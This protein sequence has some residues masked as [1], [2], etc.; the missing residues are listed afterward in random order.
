MTIYQDGVEQEQIVL[1]TLETRDQMHQMMK[2]KGFVLKQE[3]QQE[4][5]EEEMRKLKDDSSTE[6]LDARHEALLKRRDES[7]ERRIQYTQPPGYSK[8]LQFMVGVGSIVLLVGIRQRRRRKVIG[9]GQA[10]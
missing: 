3:H 9:R 10:T 8:M 4:Q 7:K 5:E 1:H 6:K 2:D